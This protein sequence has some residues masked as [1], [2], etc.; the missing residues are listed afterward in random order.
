LR[1]ASSIAFAALLVIF[2]GGQASAAPPMGP[3]GSGGGEGLPWQ[4]AALFTANWVLAAVAVA[5]LSR[6]S[7]RSDKPKKAE[8]QE[9]D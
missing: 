1:R 6:P 2:L 9:L 7:K 3:P 5:V 4:V 8:N